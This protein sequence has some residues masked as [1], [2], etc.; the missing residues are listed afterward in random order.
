MFLAHFNY[1]FS[2]YIFLTFIII[3]HLS[4]N[5]IVF[6][7]KVQKKNKILQFSRICLVSAPTL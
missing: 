2:F 6:Y 5:A 1:S 4:Y 3:S 7:K